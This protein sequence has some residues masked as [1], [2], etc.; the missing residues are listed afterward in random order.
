MDNFFGRLKVEMFYEERFESMNAFKEALKS[1][2]NYY[3]NDRISL[4]LKG[5]S[6]VHYR[7]HSLVSLS[8]FLGS[9]H[10]GLQLFYNAKE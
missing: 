7:T 1:Y 9:L 10:H 4:K 6:P 2:I 5:M 8:I 3:N